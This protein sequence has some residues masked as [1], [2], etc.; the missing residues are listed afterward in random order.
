MKILVPVKRMR[1]YKVKLRVKAA[2]SGRDLANIKIS[3]NPLDEIAGEEAVRLKKRGAVT[4]SL[5]RL[6]RGHAVPV[7]PA[8]CH[9][10]QRRPRH[11]GG[12]CRRTIAPG[13]SQAA[14]GLMDKELPGLVIL[15]KQAIGDV[16]NQTG[17]NSPRRPN[18]RK[19]PS[20]IR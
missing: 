12:S 4:E 13:R 8:H 15:D 16:C 18:C 9:G 1:D 5:R 14:Q 7:N 19:A 20:P 2:L 3:M 10:H 6:L 17:Q 11:P